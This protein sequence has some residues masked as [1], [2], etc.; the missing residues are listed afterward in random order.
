[1]HRNFP[2]WNSVHTMHMRK[3]ILYVVLAKFTDMKVQHVLWSKL[4]C[5]Y[6]ALH[7]P[8]TKHAQHEEEHMNWPVCSFVSKFLLIN[9]NR[10]AYTCKLPR[11]APSKQLL[12]L[13]LKK[14]RSCAAVFF[15]RIWEN[16]H[17]TSHLN[18]P[19]WEPGFL[20]LFLL[21][22]QP[23]GRPQASRRMV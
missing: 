16:L 21:L 14:R 5:T 12:S 6:K 7:T 10:C 8:K 13:E 4:P 20:R 3:Y 17:F 1:M 18:M 19:I 2:A 22:P 11:H 23:A 15:L 9:D